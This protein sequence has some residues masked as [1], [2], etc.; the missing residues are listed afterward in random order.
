MS[1]GFFHEDEHFQLIEFAN[2]KMGNVEAADLPWEFAE[3]MRPTFQVGMVYVVLNLLHAA[4]IHDPF[5]AT[6]VLRVIAAILSFMALYTFFNR[7]KPELIKKQSVYWFAALSFFLWYVPFIS[8][9][10]SSEAFGTLFFLFA[11]A[12]YHVPGYKKTG[13]FHYLLVGLFLGLSFIS[14]FQMGFM[15]LGIGLWVLFIRKEPIKNIGVI[16]LG[17]AL[18][19]GVGMLCDYWFYGE[20]VLSAYHYFYQNLVENKAAGFGTSPVWFYAQN[21]PLFV[22]PLFGIIIVPCIIG[23]FIKH[24]RHLFTWI[25]IPFLLIHHL[26]GH[27]EMRFLF[28]VAPFIPFI[29]IIMLEKW[30]QLRY[31]QFLKYPFWVLN[32]VFLIIMSCKPAY[33]NVGVF[34]YLYRHTEN[35]PVYFIGQQNP[36][37]MW[38]PEVATQ[39]YRPGVDLTMR[40][41]YQPNLQPDAVKDIAEL[42]TVLTSHPGEG[43]LVV[44]TI[45]YLETYE[46]Q[47]SQRGIHHQVVYNTYHSYFKTLNY[48]NWMSI[49][50]VGVWT[51]VAVSKP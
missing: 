10:F 23:F 46:P 15:I 36:F 12:F 13:L 24:P 5:T 20:W 29:I 2:Y 47:L 7:Y 31:V 18:S 30:K 37:R 9:R 48:G 21:T 49:E 45:T 22:F 16:F 25:L 40:F 33:D 39:P 34:K 4:G 3:K 6:T 14:R 26:I 44:R 51:I 11:I 19:F 28:P 42:D 41:Y 50:D 32:I 1:E 17:F 8:V 27:K 35:K 43:L 38:I